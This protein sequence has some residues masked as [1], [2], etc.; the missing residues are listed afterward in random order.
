[1]KY[2]ME[3]VQLNELVSETVQSHQL[4]NTDSDVQ[5]QMSLN[6]EP[7]LSIYADRMRLT[8]VMNNI[9]GNALKFTSKGSVIVET[10]K[11]GGEHGDE[12]KIRVSDTGAGIAPDVLPRIFGKF[13]THG[14]T[15][16]NQQGSG[17]G[18]FISKSIIETH[19]GRISASNNPDGVGSTFTITLPVHTI[20]EGEPVRG[21]GAASA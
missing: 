9:V 18:L 20:N 21:V 6:T 7:G 1:M 15:I 19:G 12:V 10:S 8:Q 3:K 11:S 2:S 14:G 5:L 13:V 16:N 4:V 17:L